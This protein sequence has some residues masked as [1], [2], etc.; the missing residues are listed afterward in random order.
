MAEARFSDI[1]NQFAGGL[2]FQK[3]AK[4]DKLLSKVDHD[5]KQKQS[6]DLTK[7]KLMELMKTMHE[8]YQI[9]LYEISEMLEVAHFSELRQTLNKIY[10]GQNLIVHYILKI[11]TNF[12]VQPDK[13]LES[14]Q[15]NMM[16]TRRKSVDYPEE[17]ET[18][19]MAH[20]IVQLQ[21]VVKKM[22][23]K[24]FE[25]KGT[26]TGEDMK[27]A[28]NQDHLMKKQKELMDIQDDLDEESQKISEFLKN[29]KLDLMAVGESKA[30]A[31]LKEVLKDLG[32]KK[33]I[34]N[35]IDDEAAEIEEQQQKEREQIFNLENTLMD[36]I[37]GVQKQ[38]QE[39]AIQDIKAGRALM[40]NGQLVYM[41]GV[42]SQTDKMKIEIEFQEKMQQHRKEGAERE[43]KILQLERRVKDLGIEKEA[44]I[45][46]LS[47]INNQ[48]TKANLESRKLQEQL[49][50]KEKASSEQQAVIN[51]TDSEKIRKLVEDNIKMKFRIKNLIDS[52]AGLEKEYNRSLERFR[53]FIQNSNI[54]EDQKKL[55][56]NSLDNLLRIDFNEKLNLQEMKELMV[57]DDLLKDPLFKQICGS[58][59]SAITRQVK[60]DELTRKQKLAK[61]PFYDP[62][63]DPEFLNPGEKIITRKV[64]K[65]VKRQNS[66]GEWVEEETEVEEEVVVNAQGEEL[67][68]RDKPVMVQQSKQTQQF[69]E[70]FGGFAV[71]GAK[72]KIP[73]KPITKDG[74][75]VQ[76]NEWFEDSSGKKVRKVQ[77]KDGEETY[78]VQEEYIDENGKKQIRIK[79]MKVKKDKNGNDYIEE[80]FVDEKGRK[81][82]VAKR[83][84]KDKDGNEIIEEIT[85]DE[86]GNKTIKKQKVYKDKDGNEVVEEE[87]IDQFGNATTV[88]RK[89]VKDAN[90]NQ[91][92]IEEKTDANGNKSIATIKKN[93]F[94]QDIIQEQIIDKSGKIQQVEKKM[95]VE[96]GIAITEEVTL[97][98]H[99]NKIIKRTK[100]KKDE[101]GNDIIEEETINADGSI[102]IKT[103]KKK[104]NADGTFTIETEIMDQNGKVTIVKQ[105]QYKDKNGNI[106]TEEESVD[107]QTGAKIITKTLKDQN[108]KEIVQKQIVG[109][110]GKIINTQKQVQIDKDGH[111]IE[112]EIVRGE[113]GQQQTVQ[114]KVQKDRN[115]NEIIEEIIT[116]EQ[117]NKRL[118]KTRVIKDRDG[119]NIIEEVTTNAD[120]S[121]MTV[122]KKQYKDKDGLEITEIETIDA[123]GN[124]VVIRTKKGL[125][126]EQIIEETRI[127]KDGK[128]E[129]TIKKF[130]KDKNGNIIVE[131]TQISSNG[132]KTVKLI[133]LGT[134]DREIQTEGIF[135]FSDKSQ[136]LLD[137]ILEQLG[138]MGLERSKQEQIKNWV[139]LKQQLQV[140]RT[141]KQQQQLQQQDSDEEVLKPRPSSAQSSKSLDSLDE[142]QAEEDQSDKLYQR[143]VQSKNGQMG[144]VLRQIRNQLGKQVVIGNEQI[145]VEE[146][147]EYMKK[148]RQIHARCGDN[149]PHLRRFY[150]KIGFATRKYKRRFLKMNL[151]KI[152]AKTKLPQLQNLS[153]IK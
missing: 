147:R 130:N 28:R 124:K 99:G 29:R 80:E 33:R 107:P 131:E 16:Q 75:Q 20:S 54:S 113:N 66:Q 100:I 27:N 31:N 26:D 119:N 121:K 76:L 123:D 101:N 30:Q 49:K 141:T 19:K 72:I 116:D 34:T 18:N 112:V 132:T 152:D 110:D 8:I 115:G 70:Q 82:K 89:I 126:G 9:V 102:T 10:N 149:C 84:T 135:D 46:Q 12:E 1:D 150:Q 134:E 61:V 69:L 87:L 67:R 64:M 92:I 143:L 81:Q 103:S 86:Q 78:E 120:G 114:R 129:K 108:G 65:L 122:K 74:R 144:E 44:Y 2:D 50:S 15:K 57:V 90:G 7:P 6:K 95:V 13:M 140:K 118:I 97:D 25:E 51:K 55:I 105:R 63:F 128:V 71:G 37:R 117:G 3:I 5:F 36:S 151:T 137:Q 68:A 40:K 125:N 139:M 24:V 104:Q 142:D 109:A 94:G 127:G 96:N 59:I 39:K 53:L 83:V 47:N 22:V 11:N 88:K 41:E 93:Q 56:L 133:K 45:Q 60:K 111:P 38:A 52:V 17:R 85:I 77:A 138:S 4:L 136:S 106:I 58:D 73:A 42:A 79:Q 146:F 23:K 35:E 14:L 48:L 145:S 98:E 43:S 32:K 62:L 148:M 153:T 21:P 91:V